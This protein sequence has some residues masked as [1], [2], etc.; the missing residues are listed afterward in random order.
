[1]PGK[2]YLLRVLLTASALALGWLFLSM[3]GGSSSAR[4][5]DL[6]PITEAVADALAPNSAPGTAA[7]ALPADGV[8]AVTEPVTAP[9]APAEPLNQVAGVLADVTEPVAGLV[10]APVLEPL[11]D[12]VRPVADLTSGVVE[13]LPA[14]IPQ[15]VSAITSAVAPVVPS[16]PPAVDTAVDAVL[17][18][19]EL[20]PAVQDAGTTPSADITIASG[21]EGTE[22][23]VGPTNSVASVRVP[24]DHTPTAPEA[25]SASPITGPAHRG[26]PERGEPGTAPTSGGDVHSAPWAVLDGREQSRHS[27]SVAGAAGSVNPP[28]FLG[29]N[30]PST[31]D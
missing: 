27:A 4:A 11:T 24:T 15:T 14:P 6:S 10:A 2:A 1:M 28:S 17:P 12:T 7:S 22:A 23:P 3:L 31:P 21:N 13:A 20:I 16:L 19:D 5:A 26:S 18:A 30:P 29:E 9:A 25:A 8:T